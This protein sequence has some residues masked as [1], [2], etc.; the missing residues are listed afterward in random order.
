MVSETLEGMRH[1]T[2]VEAPGVQQMDA[3]TI[4]YLA[5]ADCTGGRYSLFEVRDTAGSGPPMD[6]HSREDEAFYILEGEYDIYSA[7]GLVLRATPGT[8]IHVTRGTTQAY[9]C[10]GSGHGRMLVIASPGGLEHFFTDLSG[11]APDS[12]NAATS[13]EP[14]DFGPVVGVAKKHGIEVVGPPPE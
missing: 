5:T 7:E 11:L 9:K 8:Y 10:V 2:A 1:V 14:P 3:S 13:S 12:A 4:A 6:R